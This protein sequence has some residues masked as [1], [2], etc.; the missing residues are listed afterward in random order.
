MALI[1]IIEDDDIMAECVMRACKKA[2]PDVEVRIFGDAVAAI[3][4]LTEEESDEESE[5]VIDR[6]Q[7][8]LPDLIFLDVLLTGPDGFT[9]LNELVSYPETAK[10][11][12]VIISS[13]DFR[14]KDLSAYGVVATLDK[15]MMKPADIQAYVKRY[16]LRQSVSDNNMNSDRMHGDSRANVE[17]EASNGI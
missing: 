5:G 7:E 16:A 15:T 13:L 8:R 14:G 12:V 17:G 10:I 4:G 9:Y 6:G 11:P 3:E 1:D 2:A